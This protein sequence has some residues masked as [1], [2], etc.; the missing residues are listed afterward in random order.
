[1][2]GQSQG[3]ELEAHLVPAAHG[4][5]RDPA[6]LEL[7]RDHPVAHELDR[8]LLSQRALGYLSAPGLEAILFGPERLTLPLVHRGLEA[9]RAAEREELAVYRTLP[10]RR[11]PWAPRRVSAS[12]PHSAAS[13]SASSTPRP[14]ASPNVSPAANESPHP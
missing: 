2:D 14:S 1:M 11:S 5:P 12:A 13:A 3:A 8:L 10:A 6:T 7:G 9:L 4:G